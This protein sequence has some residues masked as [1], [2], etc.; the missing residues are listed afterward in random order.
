[1]EEAESLLLNARTN[2]LRGPEVRKKRTQKVL[3][4]LLDLYDAWDQPEKAAEYRALLREA[5]GTDDASE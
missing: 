1:M 2:L 3:N 4:A 5:E